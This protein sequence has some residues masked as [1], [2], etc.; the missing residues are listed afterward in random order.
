MAVNWTKLAG[1]V[2]RTIGKTLAD[3]ATPNGYPVTI[4]RDGAVTGDAW[5]PTVGNPTYFAVKAI[6]TDV[7]QRDINGTLIASTKRMAII[8]GAAGVVPTDNDKIILGQS[9]AFVD[10][11][12]DASHAWQEIETVRTIAPAGV[13]VAYELMLAI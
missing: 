9:L 5:N 12:T 3:T 6:V 7:E 1:V 11:A 13:A 10:T 4:R 2:D 8:S